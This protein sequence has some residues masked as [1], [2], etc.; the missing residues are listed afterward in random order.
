MWDHLSLLLTFPWKNWL[1]KTKWQMSFKNNENNYDTIQ[2]PFLTPLTTK[3]FHLDIYK[4]YIMISPTNLVQIFECFHTVKLQISLSHCG[5]KNFQHND[6]IQQNSP[7][8]TNTFLADGN[9]LRT[10]FIPLKVSAIHIL[11]RNH[12]FFLHI[13]ILSS[14]LEDI[15]N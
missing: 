5:Y 13:W 9:T 11:R 8:V 15:F 7:L 2:D 10:F 12:Y 6:H 1:A 3:E 4:K 14:L